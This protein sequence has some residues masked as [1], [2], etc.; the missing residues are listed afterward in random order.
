MK[1]IQR[2]LRFDVPTPFLICIKYNGD[3]AA[4]EP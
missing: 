3:D 4:K 1:Q 2:Q